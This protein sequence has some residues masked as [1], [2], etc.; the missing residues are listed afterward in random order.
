MRPRP[1][2]ALLVIAVLVVLLALGACGGRV[3]DGV[4][5]A[6]L[7]LD[8]DDLF[9]VLGPADAERWAALRSRLR[10]S[11]ARAAR[12]ADG[13]GPPVVPRAA[14]SDGGGPDATDGAAAPGGGPDVTDGAAASGGAP[15]VVDGVQVTCSASHRTGRL[16]ACAFVLGASALAIDGA[17]GTPTGA[18]R[19]IP[20]VVPVAL[21]KGTFLDRL[22][23]AGEDVLAARV[24]GEDGPLGDALAACLA[25]TSL[26]G[27]PPVPAGRFVDL[28]ATGDG[29]RFAVVAARLPEVFDAICGDTFCEGDFEEVRALTLACAAERASGRVPRC[30]WSF[31]LSHLEIAPDGAI[32]ATTASRLC[33]IPVDAAAPAFV[34]ALAGD[35]PLYATLPGRTATLASALAGCL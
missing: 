25:T 17:T 7:A 1:A 26:P 15:D 9:G 5:V 23:A 35:D 12:R 33:P 6:E 18:A 28:R 30:T 2:L 16:H 8:H 4:T 22:E 32:S 27:V 10:S 21:P 20:C 14:A 29:A 11:L 19:T 24:A 31:A 34:A 13:G 3:A